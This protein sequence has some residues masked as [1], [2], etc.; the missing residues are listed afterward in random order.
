MNVNTFIIHVMIGLANVDAIRILTR[1]KN[2]S[3]TRIIIPCVRYVLLVCIE[4]N[5]LKKEYVYELRP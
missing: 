5:F 4:F 1:Y 2:D 3:S